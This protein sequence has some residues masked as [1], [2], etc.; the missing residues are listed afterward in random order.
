MCMAHKKKALLSVFFL[1][2]ITLYMSA[3]IVSAHV[4]WFVD[5]SEVV[6]AEHGSVPFYYLGSHEVLI[7]ALVSIC[8]VV[9]FSV[10]DRILP[11]PKRLLTF[12]D[13][14]EKGIIHIAQAL[15]GIYLI[16]ITLL[17]RVIIVPDFF[18]NS[19]LTM[20]FGAVQICAGLL[21]ILNRYVR[22]ASVL[23]CALFVCAG[24]YTSPLALAENALVLALLGYFFIQHSPENSRW[25][26][27]KEASVEIVRV[28]TGIT[29][30]VLAFTEKLMYPELGLQFLSVHHWNFMQMLGLTWF[31]DKLFVLSTGFAE[32]IF[33]VIFI[34]GYL[35]RIN[36]IAIASFFAASV[37]TMFVQFGAWEV[38][39]LVVYSAA[40]LF[41][42]YGYGH[43]RFFHIMP[44]HS[45]WRRKHLRNWFRG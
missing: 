19:P 14:H 36:T 6:A 23:A 31:T 25:R 42:F 45:F 8:I 21:F 22:T 35:T 4:K 11:Y 29:L 20:V 28:G 34:L 33:G 44:P 16:S 10:L 17:W 7:W 12:A 40:V 37:V 1:F 27:L 3:P 13:K 2:F 39:D 26:Y 15:F 41:L 43:T 18:I 24:L 38:E 5:T 32:M 30:I 9:L